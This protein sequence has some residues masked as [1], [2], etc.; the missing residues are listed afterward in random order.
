MFAKLLAIDGLNLAY[1]DETN[2]SIQNVN[3]TANL[4]FRQPRGI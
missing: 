3:Y 1:K 4:L 2:V